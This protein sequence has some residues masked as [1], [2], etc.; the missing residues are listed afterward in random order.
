MV[1]WTNSILT[2]AR[3]IYAQRGFTLVHSEAHHSYGQQ[4]VGETWELAL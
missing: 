4:L 3:A 1:L 2:A